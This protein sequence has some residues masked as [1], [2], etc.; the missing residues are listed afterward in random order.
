MTPKDFFDFA[1]KNGAVFMDLAIR[2]HH[3]NFTCITT[4]NP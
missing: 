2:K 3:M 4:I 1:K